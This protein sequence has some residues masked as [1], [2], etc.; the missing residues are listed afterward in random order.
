MTINAENAESE[1]FK[2]QC[3]AERGR[4]FFMNRVD[5]RHDIFVSKFDD[6]AFSFVSYCNFVIF[7]YEDCL[8]TKLK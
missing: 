2:T 7:Y 6:W 5:A 3:N 4:V 8:D 1:I